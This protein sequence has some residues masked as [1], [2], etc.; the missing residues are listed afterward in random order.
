M[1]GDKFSFVV[2]KYPTRAVMG[3]EAAKE[4]AAVTALPKAK[5]KKGKKRIEKHEQKG[6]EMRA[7]E[8]RGCYE[9]RTVDKRE[10]VNAPRRARPGERL[11]ILDDG[12][13]RRKQKG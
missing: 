9:Q 13:A 5:N 7:K 4:A 11:Q 10:R 1:Q 8:R 12:K 3:A 2:K 6:D